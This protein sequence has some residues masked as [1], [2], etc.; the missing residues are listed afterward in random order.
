MVY[1]LQVTLRNP[2]KKSIQIVKIDDM[3][4]VQLQKEKDKGYTEIIAIVEFEKL[5]EMCII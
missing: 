4:D 1:I 3:E 2:N 5:K